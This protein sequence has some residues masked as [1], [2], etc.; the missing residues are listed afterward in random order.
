MRNSVPFRFVVDCILTAGIVRTHYWNPG[1][2]VIGYHGQVPL[3]TSSM[4]V[5][6]S[7]ILSVYFWYREINEINI[8]ILRDIT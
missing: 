7:D 6:G 8:T 1:H 2:F 4:P 3:V 5:N